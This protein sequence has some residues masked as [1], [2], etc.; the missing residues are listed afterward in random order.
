MALCLLLLVA[1]GLRTWHLT[2]VPPGLT[3]DEASNG[4]DSAAILQGVH[5]IYFPVG[6]GHEPLYNYSVALVTLWLGQSIFTLRI[7]TVFWAMLQ[8]IITIALA[9]R[10]WSRTAALGT[11]AAYAVSFWALMMAR[12]GLRAPVLPTLLAASVLAYDHAVDAV[13]RI[14]VSSERRQTG[15][16]RWSGFVVAGILLGAS[17][18]TYMASRGMIL[19]YPLALLGFAWI[20]RR[21]FND[22]WAGTAVTVLIAILVGLPL[23]LYLRAHPELEQRIAQLGYALTELRAGDWRPIWTHITDSLPML[24]WRADPRWLYHIGG[25]PALEPVLALLFLT[26]FVSSIASVL[27][28]RAGKPDSR[29][30]RGGRRAWL[31]LIWLA[32]GLAPA[33]LAPVEYNTLHAIAAMPPVFLLIG[34]GFLLMGRVARR[35]TRQ[36]PVVRRLL[37]AAGAVALM[38]TGIEAAYAYFVTW[39]RNRDVR[40]AYHHHVVAL[41]RHFNQTVPTAPVVITSL[42][43]GEFHDPYTMEVTLHREDVRLRW[44]DGRYALFVPREAAHLFVEEQTQPRDELWHLVHK[45]LVPEMQMDFQPDDHPSWTRGYQ[46][47][48]PAT[49]A[50]IETT[51]SHDVLVY[52]GDPPPN[53]AHDKRKAPVQ[54]GAAVKLVGYQ[55]VPEAPQPGETVTLLTAWEITAPITEPLVLF[56]HLLDDQGTLIDQND[57]LDA[58]NWQWQAGDRFIQTHDLLLPD[59]AGTSAHVIALGWYTRRDVT[60]LPVQISDGE[61]GLSATRILLPLG[62]KAP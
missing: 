23:L 42:Y 5:R 40:V 57:R 52:P 7:T 20:D 56:A 19:L 6:Y 35:I 2:K 55:I 48:A 11:A 43:P 60:R 18:Y 59:S 37:L 25:R 38:L 21:G 28:A 36:R 4:H 16:Q 14:K 32:G 10:W 62:V 1:F 50:R 58:P 53:I 24:V 54:Y 29:R 34:L 51:L 12:V 13:N 39:A 17:F 61:P 8:Y 33:F 31:V 30:V 27:R 26:G 3:H 45:D 41:G 15:R 9:R 49:W 22:A 44:S 47:N 46:W